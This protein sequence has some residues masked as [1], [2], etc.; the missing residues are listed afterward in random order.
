M[1]IKGNKHPQQAN[2]STNING[3]ALITYIQPSVSILKKINNT[4]KTAN[5]KNIHKKSQQHL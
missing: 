1:L 2:N 5:V 3:K 4:N